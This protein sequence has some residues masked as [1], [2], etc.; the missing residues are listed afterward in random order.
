VSFYSAWSIGNPTDAERSVLTTAL[1]PTEQA[2]RVGY[3][4]REMIERIRELAAAHAP[5]SVKRLRSMLAVHPG[6]PIVDPVEVRWAVL[7]LRQA[8]RMSF[9]VL[10]HNLEW[11]AINRGM[12]RS[13]VTN[14]ISQSIAREEIGPTEKNRVGDWLVW[15][16]HRWPAAEM[17]LTEMKDQTDESPIALASRARELVASDKESDRR[18]ATAIAFTL[19]LLVAYSVSRFAAGSTATM[20]HLMSWGDGSGSRDRFSLSRWAGLVERNRE[21]SLSAFLEFLL[22]DELL[23]RHVFTASRRADGSSNRLRIAYDADRWTTFGNKPAAVSLTPDRLDALVSLM[24]DCKLL[25][26]AQIVTDG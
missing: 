4:R 25:S 18:L 24:M 15:A 12:S 5:L 9:E 10:F 8:Q 11:L 17:L 26:K 16:A 1:C 13:E 19:L 3:R 23:S 21:T 14:T 6:I 20:N 7:Q 22:F 2:D